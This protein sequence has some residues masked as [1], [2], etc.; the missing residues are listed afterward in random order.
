MKKSV[1]VHSSAASRVMRT[2]SLHPQH[3]TSTVASV[4]GAWFSNPYILSI[5]ISLFILFISLFF[6]SL[7]EDSLTENPVDCKLYFHFFSLFFVWLSGLIQHS[8]H[9]S[10]QYPY[11]C[12]CPPFFQKNWRR[13]CLSGGG[14]PFFQY[15][16]RFYFILNYFPKQKK[17]KPNSTLRK[18]PRLGEKRIWWNFYLKKRISQNRD[19]Y[20]I[21]REILEIK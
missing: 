7:T 9:V 18:T 17:P 2:S 4:L 10:C 1:S 5:L 12:G 21:K 6:L 19:Y 16:L 13:V 11:P 8:W 14:G 20:F 3:D 15:P